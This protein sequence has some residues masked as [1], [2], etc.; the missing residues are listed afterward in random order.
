MVKYSSS[1]SSLLLVSSSS[2]S[3][4]TG[5][6]RPEYVKGLGAFTTLQK[7]VPGR[8]AVVTGNRLR[9]SL[10][11]GLC[12]RRLFSVVTGHWAAVAVSWESSSLATLGCSRRFFGVVSRR[13]LE[14]ITG[15]WAAV[16]VSWKSSLATGLQSSF[17]RRCHWPLGCSRSFLGGIITGYPGLQSSFLRRR[18][19]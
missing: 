5:I 18:H 9:M 2:R 19:L 16:V 17:L 3:C 12:S 6:I 14:V 11:P 4:L 1:V 15:H 8:R 7:D 10:G 13:F